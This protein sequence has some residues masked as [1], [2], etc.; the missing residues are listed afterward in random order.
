[1][2]ARLRTRLAAAEGFMAARRC[3]GSAVL[4]LV[5]VLATAP[6][7]AGEIRATYHES[8]RGA[9][10]LVPYDDWSPD[11]SVLLFRDPDG[12]HLLDPGTGDR[13]SLTGEPASRARWSPDGRW[14]F[15]QTEHVDAGRRRFFDRFVVSVDGSTSVLLEENV[16]E[17]EFV[18]WTDDGLLHAW[19]PGPEDHRVLTLPG[20]RDGALPG[21]PRAALFYR[22]LAGWHGSRLHVFRRG[23]APRLLLEPQDTAYLKDSRPDG[24]AFLL[25]IPD[26]G[27]IFH[28]IVDVGGTVIAEF[29]FDEASPGFTPAA[30]TS[31]GEFLVAFDEVDDMDRIVDA[32]LYV[33]E[34][35]TG[36][37]V[38]IE[39]APPGLDPRVSPVGN[40]LAYADLGSGLH[41]GELRITRTD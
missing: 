19:G 38:R 28:R 14:I 1:M 11:G 17:P 16:S 41:V 33:V 36:R 3:F 15:L 18:V 27:P 2:F 10:S 7:P 24:G 39:G 21:A 31:D 34:I 23:E 13:T 22:R 5:G 40:R 37:R 25:T 20:D 4:A 8:F 29:P 12:T 26:E 35:S 9:G 30:F 32:K 6:A